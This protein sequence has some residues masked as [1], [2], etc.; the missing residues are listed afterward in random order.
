M[1][2]LVLELLKDLGL[3]GGR[4]FTI[5]PLLLF[6][7]I[8]M[9]RRSIGQMAVFDFLIILSLG[10]VVGADIADPDIE[11]IPTAFAILMIALLQKLFTSGMMKWPWLGKLITF[12]PLVV[13]HRGRWI[14][15]HIKRAQYT[16]DNIL[17]MLRKQGVF[18]PALVEVAVIE[19]DGDLSVLKRS[20][21]DTQ[22]SASTSSPAA[23]AYP[24]VREQKLDA[25]LL[26]QLDLKPQW[27]HNQLQTSGVR[28]E[29]IFLATVDESRTIHITRYAEPGGQSLPPIIH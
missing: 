25:L 22:D 10:S 21:G 24:I 29:E 5:F 14:Y 4:I 9:G 1:G 11:H 28:L 27:V 8:F 26:Q 20:S 16:V 13:I 2:A 15:R 6:A 19:A 23:I 7:T 17:E 12:E 3:V 18:D